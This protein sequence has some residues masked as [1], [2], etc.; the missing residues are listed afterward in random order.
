MRTSSAPSSSSSASSSS[1]RPSPPVR[2]APPPSP[3]PL[4]PEESGSGTDAASA[5]TRRAVGGGARPFG[6][7]RA[8][9]RP[10]RGVWACGPGF[11]WVC[12][13]TVTAVRVRLGALCRRRSAVAVHARRCLRADAH[14]AASTASQSCA[15]RVSCVA[16]GCTTPDGRS[17]AWSKAPPLR[18][19]ER[20]VA[21]QSHTSIANMI[22]DERRSAISFETLSHS[23]HSAAAE[24]WRHSC[25]ARRCPGG[26]DRASVEMLARMWRPHTA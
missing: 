9:S 17:P 15:P 1:G 18:S 13:A 16:L 24:P 23:G 26:V 20:G 8:L 19:Y 7:Q 25:K 6:L 14:R 12:R 5:A 22:R 11:V 21:G 4:P 2:L 3:P 10:A